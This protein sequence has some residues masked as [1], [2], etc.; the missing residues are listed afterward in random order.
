MTNTQGIYKVKKINRG[1]L[2]YEKAKLFFEDLLEDYRKI[3]E[4]GC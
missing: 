3:F 4:P 1:E 2:Q